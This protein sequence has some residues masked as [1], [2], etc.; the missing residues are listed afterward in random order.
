M[1]NNLLLG[2]QLVSLDN[3]GFTV[4]NADGERHFIFEEDDGDCCGYN[5]IE[6]KLLISEDEISRNPV[7][8]N[9]VEQDHDNASVDCDSLTITL[10]GES[11]LLAQINSCSSSGSGWQYGATVT[12]RCIETHEEETITSW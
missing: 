6:V 9:I 12:C 8:T 4:R 5:D 3:N 11:K 10:F 1:F 7:I 2:S